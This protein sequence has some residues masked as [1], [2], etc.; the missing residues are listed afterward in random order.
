MFDVLP[1][2]YQFILLTTQAAPFF[3]YTAINAGPNLPTP[4]T[5]FTVPPEDISANTL[6]STYVQHP[7][8]DYVVQWNLNVQQQL[9]PSLA[10]MV[11]YVGSR[12]IHQP[13]R[14][15]EANMVLPTKTSAGY[16]WPFDRD[17]AGPPPNGNLGAPLD[18][19]NTNF[20]SVR[21]MFYNGHSYY[22]ALE[23]QVAKRM[24]LPPPSLA[25]H[26]RSGLIILSHEIDVHATR[27]SIGFRPGSPRDST[28]AT[29]AI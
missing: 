11:A 26:Q 27:S 28:A 7:K 14:V 2:P 24:S 8:R 10:A 9:T 1:L 19:L 17:P 16:V 12:G 18:P 6:R 22:N 15:D 29:S 25:G 23:T 3:S 5:F 21:A 13:F 4:L 20:G